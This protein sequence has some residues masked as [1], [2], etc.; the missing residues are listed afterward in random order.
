MGQSG[1]HRSEGSI[2]SAARSATQTVTLQQIL[3]SQGFGTRRECLALIERGVVAVDGVAR[4][5][6]EVFA[7]Q[8][9]KFSVNGEAGV[10]KALEARPQLRPT[11][12]TNR[13]DKKQSAGSLLFG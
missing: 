1:W 9:L 5:N 6:D 7:E 4:R 2:T 11:T 3:F 13:R 8:G 10:A 12:R